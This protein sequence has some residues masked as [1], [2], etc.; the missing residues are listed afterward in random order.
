MITI[1]HVVDR[2]NVVMGMDVID[3]LGGVDIQ[4]DVVLF[5][6]TASQ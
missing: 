1:E 2:I 3:H 6:G 4:R 5:G